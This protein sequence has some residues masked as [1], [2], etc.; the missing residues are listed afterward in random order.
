MPRRGT[1]VD[2]L[3]SG[4]NVTAYDFEVV[5]CEM[6]H[7]MWLGM[8][9]GEA[10]HPGPGGKAAHRRKQRGFPKPITKGDVRKCQDIIQTLVR[11]WAAR[12]YRVGFRLRE[13]MIGGATA[14][15]LGMMAATSGTQ[16][17]L[18]M[19]AMAGL[20][21]FWMAQMKSGTPQQKGRRQRT[22]RAR[23][24]RSDGAADEATSI[25]MMSVGRTR[26]PS[27]QHSWKLKHDVWQA[28]GGLAFIETAK[29]MSELLV[30][31]ERADADG[32]DF[33][34]T[35]LYEARFEAL[36]LLTA[37]RAQ[38]V[39]MR[40]TAD[41]AYGTITW[42]ELSKNPAKFACIWA[43]QHGVRQGLGRLWLRQA[44]RLPTPRPHAH[45]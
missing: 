23:A 43:S 19:D 11:D 38:P 41:A 20:F 15:R 7:D 9:V 45:P 14:P 3:F 39:V 32:A 18:L 25:V 35:L 22:R 5:S 12:H 40:F 17:G 36:G 1:F 31:G 37:L 44:W 8:R 4:A 34:L 2:E 16:R 33:S 13:L 24:P 29:D 28:R 30:A 26:M 42:E 10:S 21:D 27:E 6:R